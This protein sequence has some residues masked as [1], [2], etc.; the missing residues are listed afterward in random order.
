MAQ[1]AGDP[2]QVLG[3]GREASDQEVRSAYRRL[4]QLHHPDHNGGSAESERRFEEVQEAY[5]RIR[6]LR[7]RGPQT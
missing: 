6:E 2:Y 5:A 1:R 7:A 4:V 3:V